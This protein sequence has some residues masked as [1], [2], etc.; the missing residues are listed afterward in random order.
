MLHQYMMIL[1]HN[2][3]NINFTI[4]I[5]LTADSN[6]LKQFILLFNNGYLIHYFS[7]NISYC[8]NLCLTIFNSSFNCIIIIFLI[9][10]GLPCTLN[11]ETKS[12]C[13]F[14]P[15]PHPPTLRI[16]S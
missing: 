11:S 6:I 5:Y 14:P 8:H 10:P 4:L 13:P 2:I 9:A 12:V 7:S 1:C 3:N 15:L 16:K